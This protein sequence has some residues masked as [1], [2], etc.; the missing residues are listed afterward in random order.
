MR[1]ISSGCTFKL[2]ACFLN[3]IVLFEKNLYEKLGS[4]YYSIT[5]SQ[6]R[7]FLEVYR[8]KKNATL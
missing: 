8:R 4:N 7:F 5:L 3:V 6:L 1:N 2:I